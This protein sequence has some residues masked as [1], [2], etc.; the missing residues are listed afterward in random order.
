MSKLIVLVGLPGSGKSTYLKSYLKNER[1]RFPP[2]TF[3]YS[4]D[5]YIEAEAASEGKTYDECFKECIKNASSVMDHSLKFSIENDKHVIWDQTNMTSKKRRSIVAKFPVSYYRMCYCIVPPRS[6]EEWNE[7]DK[8][9]SSRPG[10]TI[11]DHVVRSMFN[12]YEEPELEE[13]FDFIQIVNT[14]GN[15]LK[16]KGIEI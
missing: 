4:T 12:S 11:P 15:L 9:L 8:R 3:V 6:T 2:D 5:I 10:K 1:W 14:F 16:E 13:G 7:L